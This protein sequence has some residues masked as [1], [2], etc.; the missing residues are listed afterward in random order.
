[1]GSPGARRFKSEALAA[2]HKGLNSLEHEPA[3]GDRGTFRVEWREASCDFVGVDE[4][5]DIEVPLDDCRRRARFSRAIRSA[6][7][8]DVLHRPAL[9]AKKCN[10]VN[11]IDPERQVYEKI[12]DISCA[13]SKYELS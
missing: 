11:P 5:V 10:K 6:D 12:K 2:A 9:P 3:R 13:T 7:N 8:D 4:L 1:M